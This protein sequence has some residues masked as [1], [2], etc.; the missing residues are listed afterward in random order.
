[1]FERDDQLILVPVD[2]SEDSRVAL[3]AGLSM[4]HRLGANVLILHV[5]HDPS[6]RPGFYK[7]MTAG[8]TVMVSM[9][10]AAKEMMERFLADNTVDEYTAAHNISYNVKLIQGLPVTQILN[11]A[12]REE[13]TMIVMGSRGLTG[14]SRFLLGSKAERVVQ[15][16]PIPVLVVK[17]LK[18]DGEYDGIDGDGI[19]EEQIE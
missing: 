6:N 4:A 19:E 12:K 8:S 16:S 1:M 15:L 11:V 7:S 14:F 10:E 3:E 2:F 17:A 9:E 18:I 13:A 5:V